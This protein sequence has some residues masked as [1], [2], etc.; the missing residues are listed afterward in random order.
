MI[1]EI[2]FNPDQANQLKREQLRRYVNYTL[3]YKAWELFVIYWNSSLHK[4]LQN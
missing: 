1:E 3:I 2:L 4:E